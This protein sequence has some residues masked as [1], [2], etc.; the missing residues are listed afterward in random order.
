MY[1]PTFQNFI[2]SSFLHSSFLQF[3][4]S[5]FPTFQTFSFPN[6]WNFHKITFP[7]NTKRGCAWSVNLNILQLLLLGTLLL[8]DG[9]R[10]AAMHLHIWH[11][12]AWRTIWWV[13]RLSATLHAATRQ[14][15]TRIGMLLVSEACV[16][17]LHRTES[18]RH[19]WNWYDV[20]I[21]EGYFWHGWNKIQQWFMCFDM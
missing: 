21:Y 2:C 15:Q 11:V 13:T 16:L 12:A 18:T 19:R 5:S 1:Y 14:G 10:I 4:V 8:C 6:F 20:G 9:L 3:F 7:K 17:T